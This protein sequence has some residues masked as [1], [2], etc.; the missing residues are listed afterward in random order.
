MKKPGR[1]F[2]GRSSILQGNRNWE[3]TS[4]NYGQ[5][6]YFDR[7]NSGSEQEYSWFVSP[8]LDFS[9]AV[10]ASLFFDLSYRYKSIDSIKDPAGEVFKILVSRDC[11]N[12][13]NEVLFSSNETLLSEGNLKVAVVPGS[14]TDWKQNFLNLNSLVGEESIRIA[15]VVSNNI[16]SN[17]YLDNIEFFLSDD[18]APFSTSDLYSL[19]PK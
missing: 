2:H 3:V 10:T 4:T 5:S 14:S 15:F 13:F 9:D 16:S 7:D 19:Y 1:K 8:T 12:T 17:I 11:G 6:L 18:P